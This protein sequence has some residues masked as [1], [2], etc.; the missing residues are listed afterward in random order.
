[1]NSYYNIPILAYHK[2]EHRLE[3][4]V[5][6]VF[7]TQFEKQMRFLASRG[8]RS[9]SLSEL[10]D[11]KQKKEEKNV[12][13]TFDDAYQNVIINGLSI[14]KEYGFKAT[15]FVVSDFVGKENLWDVNLGFRGFRHMGWKDLRYLVKLGFE[16]GSHSHAHP[17]LTKISDSE[18]KEELSRSKNTLED[19]LGVPVRFIS[20]PFGRYSKRV[21]QIAQECG[22]SGGVC[23]SHPFKK[24]NDIFELEREAVYIFDTLSNFE[25]KLKLF[26]ETAFIFEK[27]KGRIVNFF[28]GA[29]FELKRM[30]VFFL[31]KGQ[32]W[33][34]H[35]EE[36]NE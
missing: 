17:D 10:L 28:A 2:I 34:R 26:G 9:I 35:W 22:Y 11:N 15:V 33:I 25:A 19:K 32:K 31:K 20:Y 16:I 6:T 27:M 30:K 36:K 4:G 1:V 5:T 23:L 12:A 14:M 18:V 3:F 13:L 21:K 7:P 24:R 29:T 8:Y